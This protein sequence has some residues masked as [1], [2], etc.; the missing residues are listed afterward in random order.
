MEMYIF[1]NFKF[2]YKVQY[3][4]EQVLGSGTCMLNLYL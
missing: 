3:M 2:I 1:L 4:S